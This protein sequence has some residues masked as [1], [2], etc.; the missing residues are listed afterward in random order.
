MALKVQRIGRYSLGT[1]ALVCVITGGLLLSFATASISG[2]RADVPSETVALGP[3]GQT[4]AL[5]L[6][7]PPPGADEGGARRPPDP[8]RPVEP[9]RPDEPL[10]TAVVVH[11]FGAS[12]E[13]MREMSYSLARAGFEVYAVDLPG[14]GRS[15]VSLDAQQVTAWFSE[16]LRDIDRRERPAGG[17]YLVGHSLGTLIV[18]TGALE[19]PDLDIRAVVAVSPIF[20][21]ITPEEPPN[22]LA[23]F[24]QSELPGVQNAALEALALGTGVENP[25]LETVYGDFED[26]TA[27]SAGMVLTT[28][29]ASIA[30]HR[31][32]IGLVIQW[33]YRAT[34][35]PD[36][37]L[38]RLERAT[39]E[40]GFGFVGAVLLFM[41]LFLYLGSAGGL[42]G[43]APRRPDAR[44]LTA[45]ARKAA[46]K[47]EKIL[48]PRGLEPEETLTEGEQEAK[49]KASQLLTGARV[50]P[51]LFALAAVVTTA[52]AAFFGWFTF[53]GQLVTEYVSFYLLVF[54]LVLIPFL[55]FLGRLIRVGPLL[56]P[57]TR[58]GYLRSALFGLLLFGLVFALV[59]LFGTHS[60]LNLVPPVNRLALI[61][62]LAL[63]LAPFSIIDEMIRGTVHDRIGLTWG[64]FVVL[65]GKLII[66]LSWYTAMILPNPPQGL[67]VVVGPL[68][69]IFVTLDLAGTFIYN[70]HGNW[71]APAVLKTLS[72]A[73]ILGTVFP[74]VV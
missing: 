58:G 29:H 56:G 55:V 41:G 74:L 17:L 60:M 37:P 71:V 34:G 36:L 23:L 5:R 51:L 31:V 59:G 44:A 11:G 30:N 47:P 40:R 10:G 67:L 13:F 43:H 8:R 57:S 32:T 39:S 14:H 33:L 72:L 62:I 7:A 21:A 46:G 49:E 73:W 19:N 15:A 52:A 48:T 38:P 25:E 50:I 9:R 65:I 4:P 35:L 54:A 66:Y 16:I 68:L 70:E 18:T 20:S 26:G 64:L 6:S 24:G 1:I 12:K 22:Y 63:L 27:R 3:A 28:G 69:Q 45:E 42:L 61:G 53:L 2:S